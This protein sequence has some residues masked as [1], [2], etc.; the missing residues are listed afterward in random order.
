MDEDVLDTN[1]FVSAVLKLNSLPFLAVRWIDQHGGLLKS[2]VTEQEILNALARPHIA[3]A[4]FPPFRKDLAKRLASAELIAITERIA[5][6][7]DPTEFPASGAQRRRAGAAARSGRSAPL[8][9]GLRRYLVRLRIDGSM[10]CS[11][12]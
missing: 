6:C 7:R 4:T 2:A 3:A 11:L 10:T 12:A 8:P 5:A 1:V 9:A